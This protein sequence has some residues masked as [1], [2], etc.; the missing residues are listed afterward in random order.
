MAVFAVD[1]LSGA[2]TNP[3]QWAWYYNNADDNLYLQLLPPT[4]AVAV[5]IET[6]ASSGAVRASNIV[7]ITT[8]SAHGFVV[9]DKVVVADVQDPTF[10][11]EF[12]VETVPSSTTF[13]YGQP[14]ANTTSGSNGP[15]AATATPAYPEWQPVTTGTEIRDSVRPTDTLTRAKYIGRDYGTFLDEGLAWLREKYG[16]QFDDFVASDFGIMFAKYVSAA[17]DT[18]SWYMDKEVTEW[19]YPIMRLR[20]R[21]E[22]LA[23]MSAYKPRSATACTVDLDLALTSG[24]YAFDVMVPAGFQFIG[25]NSLVFE[26]LFDVTFFAGQTSKTGISAVQG[27]T[28]VENFVS[29]GTANQQFRLDSIDSDEYVAS[30]RGKFYVAGVLWTETDFLPYERENKYEVIYGSTPPTIYTGDGVVGNIP[31]RGAEIVASYIATKGKAGKAAIANTIQSSVSSL[32]VNLTEIPI[33]VNNPRSASGGD[34]PETL[35]E[36]KANA[37][38][39]FK[40]ADRGVTRQDVTTLANLYSS[41]VYGTVA[42]AKAN[43]VRGIADDLAMQAKLQALQGLAD[44]LDTYMDE[45]TTQVANIATARAACTT[46]TNT[47][48]TQLATLDMASADA[49]NELNAGK[50]ALKNMP[51]QQLFARGDGVSTSFTATLQK[52]PLS[53]GSVLVW[54]DDLTVMTG[55]WGTDGDA[56]AVGGWLKSTSTTFQSSWVGRLIKIGNEVR[57]IRAVHTGENRIQYSGARIVGTGLFFEIYI[58]VVYGADDGAGAF[59]GFG[60]GTGSINYTTGVVTFEV[61]LSV[62]SDKD[63]FCQYGYADGTVTTYLDNAI[64][65]L[66]NVNTASGEVSTAKDEIDAQLATIATA[67]T[68]IANQITLSLAIPASMTT[69]IADLETYLDENLSGECR[70]NIVVV[71]VLVVD[72]NGF[73]AAPTQTL[74]T[75]VQNY[76]NE[77]AVVPT[78]IVTVSGYYNLIAVSMSYRLKIS[79]PYKFD[80]V[81]ARL[82]VAVDEMLKGRN[83]GESL[84]RSDYYNITV[85]DRNGS[86]G[87]AGVGYADITINGT[88]F[89]DP[90]NQGVAPSVDAYGNLAVPSTMILT[91]GTIVTQEIAS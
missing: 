61:T 34:D 71:Q 88:A 43:I 19:F 3:L 47:I 7:T 69:A 20:S 22:L 86:G 70:A 78:T 21:A 63:I 39:Y 44:D 87:I 66:A 57:V 41:G 81:S 13:T 25:P 56:D 37:P 62:A 16:D 83:Y 84:Y 59:T 31:D 36:I 79:S 73:Y 49:E 28:I 65:D 48:T 4:S 29:D 67:E 32:V 74:L 42:K 38:A 23:R 51:Y 1:E 26:L 68:A 54:V 10:D 72:E 33:S 55:G 75:A 89:P 40:T 46:Q 85:P 14:G 11:G 77:H 17:L 5:Q 6:V 30:G 52:F 64:A 58:P 2:P 90:A 15:P 91:K 76:L 35:E 27:R 12:Y 60:V 80:E 50:S 9:G 45:I 82:L 53:A 8:V 24:P 18:L